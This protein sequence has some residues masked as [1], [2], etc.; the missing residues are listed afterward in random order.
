MT[1][2]CAGKTAGGGAA[3][4]TAGQADHRTQYG[5]GAEKLYEINDGNEPERPHGPGLQSA[6]R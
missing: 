6:H 1:W 3:G 5:D 4:K 2:F